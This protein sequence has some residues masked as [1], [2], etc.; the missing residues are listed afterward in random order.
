MR[1]AH[2]DRLALVL[3]FFAACE[4]AGDDVVEKVAEKAIADKGRN[5][6][7][8]IDRERGS[9]TIDL[10]SATRPS[11]WPEDVPFYPNARRAR[12]EKPDGEKQKLTLR[13]GDRAEEMKAFYREQLSDDGWTVDVADG[14]LRARKSGREIVARFQS[15]DPVRG[16]RAVI[17][18]RQP[19]G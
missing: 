13:S 6:S 11:R 3:L 16:T 5:S 10:G 1:L 2:V 19:R 15:K 14:T 7:V 8:T 17:E 12:A 9:I 4:R 18:V